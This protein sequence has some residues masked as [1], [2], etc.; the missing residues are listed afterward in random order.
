MKTY[1][2]ISLRRSA[3]KKLNEVRTGNISRDEAERLLKEQ[4]RHSSKLREDI[5]AELTAEYDA[6]AVE[7]LQ[8]FRLI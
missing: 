1:L 2:P 4:I 7:A 6:D 5:I 8:Y 3:T